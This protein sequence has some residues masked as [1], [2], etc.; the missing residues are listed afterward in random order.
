MPAGEAGRIEG[1]DVARKVHRA[2]PIFYPT[3]LPPGATFQEPD[4]Y[5]EIVNPWVYHLLDKEGM[6]HRA[7]RMVGDLPARIRS[8][9]LRC[10]GY[11][12]LGDPPILDNPTETTTI[13]GREYSIYTDSGNIK[14]VAWHRGANTYWISNSLQ[15]SLTNK[16]MMG[17]AESCHVIMAKRRTAKHRSS[18]R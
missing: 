6:R 5:E 1:E 14:L 17:V 2:F 10:P 15:Q 16:Q 18:P 9:L 3:R 7:Y 13:G 11:P 4:P 12:G 8:H